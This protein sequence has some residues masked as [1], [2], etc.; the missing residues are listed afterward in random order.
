MGPL[1]TQGA[2]TLKIKVELLGRSIDLSVPTKIDVTPE[3]VEASGDFEL[4]HADLG[5]QPFSVMMGALQV[6]EK[7]SFSY[8]I[9]A[10]PAP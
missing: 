6:A 4:N 5:M 8:R 1:D 9:V 7:M 10:Q 3:R 2:Q